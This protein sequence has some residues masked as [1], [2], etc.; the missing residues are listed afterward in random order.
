[1][2][3]AIFRAIHAEGARLYDKDSIVRWI[4]T[5]GIDEKEFADLW[6]SFSIS[7]AT[8]NADRRSISHRVDSVPSLSVDG[9]FRVAIG[10]DGTVE[11]FERQLAAVS[12]LIDTIRAERN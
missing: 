9:R 12:E 10:D 6:D 8:R 2:H 7:V 1:M 5:Q 4:R 3:T 11:Y